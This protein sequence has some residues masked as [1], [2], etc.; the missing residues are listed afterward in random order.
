MRKILIASR[1]LYIAGIIGALAAAL[2]CLIMYDQ[3]CPAYALMVKLTLLSLL[4]AGGSYAI[5]RVFKKR[6]AREQEKKEE[7]RMKW[8][9]TR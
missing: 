8:R 6:R 7:R 5:H 9:N 2:T 3:G 1:I 4:L